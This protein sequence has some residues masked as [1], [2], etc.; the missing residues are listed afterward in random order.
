MIVVVVVVD[1]SQENYSLGNENEKRFVDTEVDRVH[2]VV[3][4]QRVLAVAMMHQLLPMVVEIPVLVAI[5]RL[6]ERLF[7]CSI[8]HSFVSWQP[9]TEEVA[10]MVESLFYSR[11]KKKK[12]KCDETSCLF[13]ERMMIRPPFCEEKENQANHLPCVDDA[14]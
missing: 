7:A 5:I 8:Y 2:D 10:R 12:K 14:S 13:V 6:E 1:V 4:H 11:K 9:T 3:W